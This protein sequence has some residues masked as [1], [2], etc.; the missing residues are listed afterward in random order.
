MTALAFNR[1]LKYLFL[2]D[3]FGNVTIWSLK[4]LLQ[5]LDDVK[6]DKK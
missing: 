2:G 3:E 1:A 5:K 4:E 6:D